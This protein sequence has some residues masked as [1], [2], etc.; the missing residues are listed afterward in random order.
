MKVL[1]KADV[2]ALGKKNEIV[3]A[4]EGYAR[5]FLFPRNLAV[6]ATA[7]VLRGLQEVKANEKKRE[8]KELTAAKELAEK[9][10]AVKVEISRKTGEGGKLF[11]S[12]AGKDIAEK[13]K[14][15]SML[16]IDRRKVEL[17]DPIKSLGT[18]KVCVRLH[19]GVVAEIEVTVSE[20]K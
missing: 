12:V 3:E 7:G 9:L 11:G 19:Q 1:L 8:D 17:D 20:A 14:E 2:K 5:N 6:E 16:D 13:L 10:S 18:Y 4:S 15:I